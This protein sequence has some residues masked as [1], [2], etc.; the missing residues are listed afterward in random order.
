MAD[1]SSHRRC[2]M[3]ALLGLSHRVFCV[4]F[5]L[6][7]VRTLFFGPGGS[8]LLKAGI[9][10]GSDGRRCIKSFLSALGQNGA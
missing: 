5:L 3:L 7:L 8:W 6:R 10:G 9:M 2:K 1:F 4:C